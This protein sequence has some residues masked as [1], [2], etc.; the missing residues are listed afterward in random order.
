MRSAGIVSSCIVWSCIVALLSLNACADM[1]EIGNQQLSV[2]FDEESI[3]IRSVADEQLSVK[4]LRF[5]WSSSKIEK[6]GASD[7]TWG[8]GQS[9]VIL[10]DNGWLTTL[11]L[12]E[13]SPFLHCATKVR[14]SKASPSQTNSLTLATWVADLGVNTDQLRVIGTGGLSSVAE[15]QGSYAFSAVADPDT[16]RGIVAGWLTHERGIGV[17]FPTLCGMVVWRFARRSTSATSACPAAKNATRR[18]C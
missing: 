8:R 17:F 12:Y 10:S 2:R 13:T 5:P 16:R 15:A 9:I 11:T 1:V 3:E 4:Q 6:Q 14:N 7:D 18:F